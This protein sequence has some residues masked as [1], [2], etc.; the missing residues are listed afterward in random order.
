MSSYG[1]VSLYF[2]DVNFSFVMSYKS[3]RCVKFM[4]SLL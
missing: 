3:R 1:R 2:I 4:F